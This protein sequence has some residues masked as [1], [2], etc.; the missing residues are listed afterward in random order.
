MRLF[1]ATIFTCL[2]WTQH[3]DWNQIGHKLLQSG[4]GES[5]DMSDT[6]SNAAKYRRLAECARNDALL[7]HDD[8]VR[9]QLLTISQSYEGLAIAVERIARRHAD[10]EASLA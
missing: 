1:A 7:A 9:A 2:L 3:I 6:E 5:A 8:E 10:S 4:F